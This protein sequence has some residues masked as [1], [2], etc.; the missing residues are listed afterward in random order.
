M[1]KIFGISL[2]A[3]A[4]GLCACDDES[5][6][7]S[8]C[9]NIMRA[10]HG[11]VDKGAFLVI[12]GVNYTSKSVCVDNERLTVSDVKRYYPLCLNDYYDYQECV[13]AL[14]YRTIVYIDDLV[15]VVDYCKR[16]Y[17]DCLDYYY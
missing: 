12:D 10:T 2:I 9:G 3:A 13:D 17:Y 1:K 14:D 6:I 11:T 16:R 8:M 5:L 4:I 7:E 15:G